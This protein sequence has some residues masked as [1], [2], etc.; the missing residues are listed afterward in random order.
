MKIFTALT[1][2]KIFNITVMTLNRHLRAGHLPLAYQ[3]ENKYWVIPAAAVDQFMR[4]RADGKFVLG[5]GGRKP[6]AKPAV[7]ETTIPGHQGCNLA[8]VITNATAEP[9]QITLESH[10]SN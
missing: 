9:M 3:M 10:D 2:A 4:D 1:V 6:K 7:F 5:T 8:T